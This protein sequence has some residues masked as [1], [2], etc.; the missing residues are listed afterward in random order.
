M[1]FIFFH[2][3]NT[4]FRLK[5]Q[6]HDIVIS[7]F[8]KFYSVRKANFK[9]WLKFYKH[10]HAPLRGDTSHSLCLENEFIRHKSRQYFI[11]FIKHNMMPHPEALIHNLPNSSATLGVCWTAYEP[12]RATDIQT[13]KRMR[14]N[15]HL[16]LLFF[17]L[18]LGSLRI[19]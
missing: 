19:L 14:R 4:D 3:N 5:H 18:L 2:S 15:S 8:K 10:H 9:R 13:K 16:I 7:R 17:C 1:N 12:K 11:Y 6:K